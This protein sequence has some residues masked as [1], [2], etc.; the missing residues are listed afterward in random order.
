[1]ALYPLLAGH[2]DPLPTPPSDPPPDDRVVYAFEA[3]SRVDLRPGRRAKVQAGDY[4]IGNQLVR[5]VIGGARRVPG[6]PNWTG[7]LLDAGRMGKPGD[8]LG[9]AI[10]VLEVNGTRFQPRYERVKV[11]SDGSAG[12]AVIAVEGH[13]A[14]RP[15]VRVVSE[16]RL[17]E[18]DEH[19]TM[20][21]TL[22]NRGSRRVAS[23]RLG[24]YVKW[25]NARTFFPGKGYRLRRSSGHRSNWIARRGEGSSFAWF[26]AKGR[27][28]TTVLTSHQGSR[29]NSAMKIF[30]KR[31]SLEPG[32]SVSYTRYLAVGQ[33]DIADVARIVYQVRGDVAARV[34]GRVTGAKGTGLTSVRVRAYGARGRELVSEADTDKEGRFEMRLKPG[35]YQL[36]AWEWGRPDSAPAL[37]AVAGREVNGVE[38]KMRAPGRLYF[39]VRDEKTDELLPARLILHGRGRTR[40]PKFVPAREDRQLDNVIYTE[41]GRGLRN[42][43]PGRYRVLVTRGPEY[44]LA[45]REIR[46][47]SGRVATIFAKLSRVVDTS[48][49]IACDFH[50]HSVNSQDSL[51]NLRERVRSLVS[52]NVELAVPTDHNHVTDYR[53]IIA[54][55]GLRKWI[56]SIPGDEITTTGFM[57]GHFNAFPV[58]P[59]VGTPGEGAFAHHRRLPEEIFA[60]VRSRPGAE[61]VIQVN[62][63]RLGRKNGYWNNLS[64]DGSRG[65]ARDSRYA[66]GFDAIE[67][68][69]GLDRSLQRTERV[70]G[71]WFVLLNRGFRYTATGN[72]DSHRLGF[73]EVGYPRNYVAVSDDEPSRVDPYEVIASVKA[74][75]VVVTNGPFLRVRAVAVGKDGKPAG[76]E[77]GATDLTAGDEPPPPPR[78]GAPRPPRAALQAGG[79]GQLVRAGPGGVL[80]RIEVQAAPWVDLTHLEVVGNGDVVERIQVPRRRP[81]RFQGSVLLRPATDTWYVVLARGSEPLPTL[82]RRKPIPP[83]GFANPIWVDANGDGAFTSPM[84]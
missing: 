32:D 41:T 48:G 77:P 24:D 19:L 12:S 74:G 36:V 58:E 80:L 43:P 49:F 50:L 16:Y 44:T 10:P 45:E 4:V 1:V 21:T 59:Q 20:T 23:L 15:S 11:A 69:N 81:V 29:Y 25:T 84:K 27:M 75:R 62:H 8:L 54:E 38:L 65:V 28:A 72:S 73:E 37:V 35:S 34:S 60:E 13:V 46:V 71:E 55:M 7:Y 18:W 66:S 51:V 30:A 79:M 76:P 56:T 68:F 78:T 53:P 3:R 2:G 14:D 57:L 52:E 47:R 26:V 61:R 6:F 33:G 67:V 42:I 17:G 40:T 22:E 39:E 70:L 31:A 5:F 9:A 83:L 82:P 64:F 63:P